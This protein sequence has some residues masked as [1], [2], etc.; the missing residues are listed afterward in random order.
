[1]PAHNAMASWAIIIK[2]T[3]LL[4][5]DD[6]EAVRQVRQ[7]YKIFDAAMMTNPVVVEEPGKRG[8]DPDHHD[9]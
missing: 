3:R 2:L 7:L 9:Q 5:K 1:M 4:P 8:Q 6:E